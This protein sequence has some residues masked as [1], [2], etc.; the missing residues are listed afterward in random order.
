[1]RKTIGELKAETHEAI[2]ECV[3]EVAGGAFVSEVAKRENITVNQLISY[4][5][6]RGVT[7][8]SDI[9]KPKRRKPE[10]IE[11]ARKCGQMWEDG[12]KL[13]DIAE[14]LGVGSHQRVAQLITIYNREVKK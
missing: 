1:M 12:H 2:K 8:L 14:T 10:T 6:S 7:K 5:Y 13:R 3:Y 11:M 9:K 4:C